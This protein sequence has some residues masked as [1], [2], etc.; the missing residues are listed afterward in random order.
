METKMEINL[1]FIFVYIDKTTELKVMFLITAWNLH[2]VNLFCE[3]CWWP[4]FALLCFIQ[5]QA[6]KYRYTQGRIQHCMCSTNSWTK[7]MHTTSQKHTKQKSDGLQN[8]FKT[9]MNILN[10]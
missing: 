8:K 5:M 3:K 1:K 9:D 2:F 4:L 7:H 10:A 6:S